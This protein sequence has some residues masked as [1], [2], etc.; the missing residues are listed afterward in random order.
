M[1]TKIFKSDA[2]HVFGGGL[3][4]LQVISKI[5]NH[6]NSIAGKPELILHDQGVNIL[7]AWN[8][9]ECG[10]HRFNNGFHGIEM[11]RAALV[12]DF[13]KKSGCEDALIEIPNFRLLCIEG[14]EI[15]FE[16][17]LSDWPED[18]SKGLC[19]LLEKYQD[20]CSSEAI[21]DHVLSFTKIGEVL[22]KA[23]TR[24][25][26]NLDECW[27]LLFPWFFPAEFQF[28]DNSDEGS[29][30]QNNVRNGSLSPSYLIPRSG[31][32]EDIRPNLLRWLGKI[33]VNLV[34]NEKLTLKQIERIAA[35]RG[36]AV[37]WAASS[38]SLIESLDNKLSINCISSKR[39][40]N[41]LIY[42][43][44]RNFFN[45]WKRR[46]RS[47]PSEVLYL[48][49]LAPEL[50]RISF[51]G[52]NSEGF[53]SDEAGVLIMAECFTEKI[54]PDDD[55]AKRVEVCLEAHFGS[56]VVYQG[57][58]YGRPMLTLASHAL[59]EATA[60]VKSYALTTGI[61]FPSIYYGPINM[62]KCGIIA[63]NFL[64]N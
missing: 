23:A 62:A 51:P 29:Q 14:Y 39:H 37:V 7:S 52:Y 26:D 41:L 40:M 30:F 55:L 6:L 2:V 38:Y 3:I 44:S 15:C 53:E 27:H 16:S 35:D 9:R 54:T 59:S 36:S 43:L 1:H 12:S 20:G 5:R 50:N 28:A 57:Q 34:L 56:N 48:D 47:T 60:L 10:S 22:S 19:G 64:N 46:F 63:E 32:F 25:S 8:S 21:I 24:F 31:I 42:T 49:S 4:G 33:D 18:I 61:I 13:L 45:L 11:P 58:V 17:S